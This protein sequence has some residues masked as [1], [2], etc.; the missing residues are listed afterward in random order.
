MAARA[1]HRPVVLATALDGSAQELID[2]PGE[3]E[4]KVDRA[5]AEVAA[6]ALRF[7]AA[8]RIT[9]QGREWLLTPFN[10]P[11]RLIVVGAVHIAESLC[12]LARLAGHEVTLIDPR[13]AFLRPTLFPG[14]RLVG[15]WP[16]QALPG[17]HVD[18]RCAA[19]MLTHDPK[20]DDPAIAYL[21]GTPAYYLG[22]LGSRRTH[23][24]RLERLAAQGFDAGQ[25]QRLRGP[26]G[27]PI[28][29]RTPAEIAISIIAEMTA[30]LRGVP[31]APAVR[32]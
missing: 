25:L 31:Q 32:R 8:R 9:H 29:A 27:L 10:P 16:Q 23:A 14:V 11:L 20:V 18:A 3:G 5:L 28:G 7:D 12:S 4:V 26:A 30:A 22:A 17:L 15:E 2:A 21:L 1:A 24:R 19:V 6:E 13:S